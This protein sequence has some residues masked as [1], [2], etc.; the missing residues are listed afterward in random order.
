M[1][2]T[3]HPTHRIQSMSMTTTHT[4]T[5]GLESPELTPEQCKAFALI[6][7]AK[8]FPSGHTVIDC[9][10]RWESERGI[11]DEP[12][13]Q[14]IVIG[15]GQAHRDAVANFCRDYKRGC[16]QDCVLVQVTKPETYWV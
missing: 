3:P 2:I 5:V 7:A 11:I 10:G 9:T 1:G 13:L 16:F 12:S 6:A 4:I 8:Y 14:I 15:Q